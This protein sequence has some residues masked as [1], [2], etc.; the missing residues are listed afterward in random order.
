MR[1]YEISEFGSFDV[2]KAVE[3]ERP[4]PGYGQVLVEFKAFSLNYRDLMTIR[5]A[6]N[7]RMKLPVVPLSDGAGV[8]VELGDG[9][10][11]W[12]VGDRVCPIF[13][14]EWIDGPIDD[15]KGRSALAGSPKWN[16][17]LREVGAFS[18]HGLVAIPDHLSFEEAATLPCA[19]VTAWNALIDGGGLRPGET[20]LTLGT[21]GVSV[22]AA[23]F[24]KMA[25][26][27]VIATSSSD[28]KLERMKE[29]GVD[30]TVN[31]RRTPEWDKEV[32]ELTNGRGVD[33]VVEVGGAGTFA[34]SVASVATGGRIAVIGVLTTEG[35]GVSPIP[36]LMRSLRLTGIYVGSRNMFESMNAAI[37]KNEMR[38]VI[39]RVYDLDDP[40]AAYE[41]MNSGKHFG[42]V[43][44]STTADR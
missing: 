27:S 21:G 3:H 29:L 7:P 33:H 10:S 4:R 14:Q 28:E 39:D 12:K 2:L 13:M 24:A 18:E 9:V 17:V 19:A 6:Y 11:R 37:A 26:A 41:Y 25:G 30:A 31:Y 23:Q 20:V 40:H 44:I 22:F 15:L 32:L 43:V 16:G 38:P 34:R 35:S 36:V 42:K 5:G 1:A 8:V